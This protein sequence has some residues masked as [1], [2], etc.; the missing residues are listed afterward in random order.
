MKAYS[1]CG[2]SLVTA[3]FAAGCSADADSDAIGDALAYSVVSDSDP[4]LVSEIVW[5]PCIE[6]AP[7]LAA[8]AEKVGRVLD[9]VVCALVPTPLDWQRPDSGDTIDIAVVKAPATGPNPEGALF[10]NPGGPNESGLDLAIDLALDTSFEKVGKNFDV[11]G[12]DPRG[13]GE[14]SPVVCDTESSQSGVDVLEQCLEDNP[15]AAFIGTKSVAWDMDYLRRTLGYESLNYLGFSYGTVL[16]A[17]YAHMFGENVGRM[18][19]DSATPAS[20]AGPE[21]AFDQETAIVKAL[22]NLGERCSDSGNECPY[23]TEAELSKIIDDVDEH[24]LKATNGDEVTGQDIYGYLTAAL[25]TDKEGISDALKTVAQ[26]VQGSS[27]AVDLIAA[28]SDGAVV[29]ETGTIISCLSAPPNEDTGKLK[30]HMSDVGVPELLGGPDATDD[31]AE[32]FSDDYCQAVPT[33]KDYLPTFRA[34][35]ETPILVVGITGDHA[36]PYSGSVAL[37]EDLGDAELLTL[38]GTGHAASYSQRSTCVDDYVTRYLLSGLL[39]PE[40]TVCAED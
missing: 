18:V 6:D 4:D 5:E 24:P 25:Y 30:Q 12:F 17:T 1:I 29:D 37:A 21:Q 27:K 14:S 19:L 34:D 10:V 39:P 40:N 35:V 26:A 3:L 9:D 13:T 33:G 38:E 31:V 32:L 15:E 11:I 23:R 20:W 7:E 28:D 36:T 2:I 8:E 16:G 22:G